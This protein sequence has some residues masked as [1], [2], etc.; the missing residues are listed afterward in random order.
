VTPTHK[1]SDE[2]ATFTNSVEI[3]K[4]IRTSGEACM[5]ALFAGWLLLSLKE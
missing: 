1:Q 5:H 2:A 4:K 3:Q